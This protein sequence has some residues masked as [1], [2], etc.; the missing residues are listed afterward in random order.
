M[1]C[2]QVWCDWP[3]RAVS[4]TH[5][6]GTCPLVM[7]SGANRL[8]RADLTMGPLNMVLESRSTASAV[9]TLGDRSVSHKPMSWNSALEPRQ[10]FSHF[11][12]PF[13]DREGRLG[14]ADAVLPE[15]AP[16]GL[17]CPAWARCV[18]GPFIIAVLLRSPTALRGRIKPRVEVVN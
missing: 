16:L 15:P 8:V 17:I 11:C 12:V 6:G 14:T 9:R 10:H 18:L 7:S 13:Q 4:R 3:L 5:H 2:H 1:T